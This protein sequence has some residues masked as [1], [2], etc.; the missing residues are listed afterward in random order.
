M[1]KSGKGRK[2]S[3]EMIEKLRQRMIQWNLLHSTKGKI[4][5]QEHKDK[6]SKSGTGQKRTGEALRHIQEANKN[7]WLGKH[8]SEES[9][10]KM[11]LTKREVN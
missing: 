5:S 10:L 9:K 4:L 7:N 11:S 3:P 1:S 6:I 2:R 8:H